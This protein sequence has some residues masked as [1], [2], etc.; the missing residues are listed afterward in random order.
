MAD[1]NP[2]GF[3]EKLALAGVGLLIGGF[4]QVILL[5]ILIVWLFIVWGD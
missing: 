2:E 1:F 5:T 4:F 3:W